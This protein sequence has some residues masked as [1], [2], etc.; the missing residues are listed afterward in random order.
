[1][2]TGTIDKNAI[3][4]GPER[5]IEL[6][7]RLEK[8]ADAGDE[9]SDNVPAIFGRLIAHGIAIV[10]CRH[11]GIVLLETEGDQENALRLRC[12]DGE[13]QVQHE[14]SGYRDPRRAGA[15]TARRYKAQD[16]H[17]VDRI[18]EAMERIQN[19]A[20]WEETNRTALGIRGWSQAIEVLMRF[21]RELKQ[22]RSRQ[23]LAMNGC[24]NN[25]D[26]AWG[27]TT[28][29]SDVTPETVDVILTSRQRPLLGPEPND[30]GHARPVL[31]LSWNASKG[32]DA[33]EAARAAVT[34]GRLVADTRG[35]G[36]T[37]PTLKGWR[38]LLENVAERCSAH[39]QEHGEAPWRRTTGG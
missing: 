8:A 10:V 27:N 36:T 2:T 14:E 32:I 17:P 25:S 35:R 3:G 7:Q 23:V 19:Q 24:M 29:D 21:A 5:L 34:G 20:G 11:R 12:T 33:D 6:T 38:K 13:L 4:R 28:I 39:V 22:P 1:M 16:R 18:K 26:D 15:A 37:M 30:Y 31:R 9:S